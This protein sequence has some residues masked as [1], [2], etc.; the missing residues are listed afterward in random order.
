MVIAAGPPPRNLPRSIV[1]VLAGFAAV[2][3]LSIG[4]DHVLHT[5]GVFPQWGEPM[6]EPGLNVLALTYRVAYGVLGGY[7]AAR[8]APRRSMRHALILGWIGFGVSLVGAIVAIR[9]ANL[10]PM[11]FP[12]ALVLTAVP[13][14]WLGGVLHA[15]KA[16]R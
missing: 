9:T 8:L 12:I 15:R 13:C 5:L 7:V 16:A 11:W 3:A 6:W 4:T 10:G 14:A 2:V 1:A